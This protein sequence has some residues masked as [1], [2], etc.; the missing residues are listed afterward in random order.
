VRTYF[1]ELSELDQDWRGVSSVADLKVEGLSAR[2]ALSSMPF[3]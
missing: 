3:S 2:A 1:L